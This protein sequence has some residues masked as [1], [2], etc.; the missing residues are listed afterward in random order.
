[1]ARTHVMH[2]GGAVR[3]IFLSRPPYLALSA[4]LKTSS[5]CAV[6]NDDYYIERARRGAANS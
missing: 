1:M 2:Q 3:F 4:S 6:K 5:N